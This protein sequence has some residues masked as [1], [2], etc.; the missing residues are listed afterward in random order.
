MIKHKWLF[1]LIGFFG[2]NVSAAK[3][4]WA[5]ETQVVKN[6]DACLAPYAVKKSAKGLN[7]V[8]LNPGAST[9][10]STGDFWINVSHAMQSAADEFG[11]SLEI[12]YAQRDHILAQQQADAVFKRSVPPDF[13]I[14]VNEKMIA[15]PIIKKANAKGIR[16]LLIL[17]ALT[18]N[19]K[20]TMGRPREKY[21]CWIGE[22]IPD[23]TKAG[24]QL[25]QQLTTQAQQL[26]APAKQLT[27]PAYQNNA[28]S[29]K[30]NILA[31][32]GD[33]V[34]PASVDRDKGL[35]DFIADNPK[36]K[37]T[38]RYVGYWKN[39][40]AQQI[41]NTA[42]QKNADI[43]VIWAANDAMALG[44][45]AA[46]QQ[47]LILNQSAQPR[48][49]KIIVGG[50]NWDTENLQKLSKRELVVSVGGHFM[51][52]GWAMV[53]LNDYATGRDFV[54]ES[55]SFKPNGFA[56]LTADNIVF[57]LATFPRLQIDAVNFLQLS[58]PPQ[59]YRFDLAGL[60]SDTNEGS[61]K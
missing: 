2:L 39:Q 49:K 20:I 21:P 47:R 57:S 50:I 36:V 1:F 16:T 41:V 4:S 60:V 24:Y 55:V 40:Q 15:E 32:S 30:L 9:G 29:K 37:L 10:K 12:I 53:L 56:V 28:S 46:I 26:T 17:N 34:T 35:Q 33:Y 42:L 19:Q 45:V 44:A 14:I 23:N 27:A 59:R 38:H 58:K 51:V 61:G 22:I 13:L 31:L 25:A 52:G 43:D 8:F 6:S 11:M 18:E 3:P 48:S 5:F 54:F 7:L